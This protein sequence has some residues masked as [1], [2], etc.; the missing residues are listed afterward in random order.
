M[1]RGRRLTEGSKRMRNKRGT[2]GAFLFFSVVEL[3]SYM[4]CIQRG[5]IDQGDIA[6]PLWTDEI[7]GN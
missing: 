5:C 3:H 6:A 2:D 4:S 1:E 7:K